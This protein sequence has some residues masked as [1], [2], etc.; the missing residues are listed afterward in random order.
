MPV[1]LCFFVGHQ[2]AFYNK[3][4]ALHPLAITA[5][6]IFKAGILPAGLTLPFPGISHASTYF[7][8]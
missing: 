6:A 8:Q 1:A 7:L 3:K 4:H 2:L 5:H